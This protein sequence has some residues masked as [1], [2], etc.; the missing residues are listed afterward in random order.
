MIILS[1][2]PLMAGRIGTIAGEGAN[3]VA[4]QNPTAGF[5]CEYPGAAM[6]RIRLAGSDPIHHAGGVGPCP[7]QGTAS[8]ITVMTYRPAPTPSRFPAGI[9][10][11]MRVRAVASSLSHLS[12]PNGL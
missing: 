2:L 9:T 8:E 11:R 6:V 4:V 7:I 5:C 3:P 1:L 12:N 10:S